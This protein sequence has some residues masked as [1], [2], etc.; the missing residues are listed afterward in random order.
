M[1]YGFK[2]AGLLALESGKNQRK[3]KMKTLQDNRN[4]KGNLWCE[5]LL[6][7]WNQ[8]LRWVPYSE[9]GWEKSSNGY[10]GCCYELDIT[11]I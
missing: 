10:F 7:P 1:T 8:G 4:E 9:R 11:D 3:E 6:T 5:T 2:C